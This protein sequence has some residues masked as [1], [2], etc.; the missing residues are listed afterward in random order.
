MGCL[1]HCTVFTTALLQVLARPQTSES[2]GSEEE[3]EA[4]ND[5]ESFYD[6]APCT[7]EAISEMARKTAN[8]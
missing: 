3:G 8:E 5:K 2:A 6:L 7:E 4:D 1:W